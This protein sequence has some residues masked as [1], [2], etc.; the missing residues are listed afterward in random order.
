MLWSEDELAAFLCC[1]GCG[2]DVAER[3]LARKV[4][5]VDHFIQM[6]D[7]QLEK[8]FGFTSTL[9]RRVVRRALRRFLEV[10][11]LQ[12]KV[13]GRRLADAMED[14]V[15]RDFVIPLEELKIDSE[16]S[17]GGFGMVYKGI[18]R[19]KVA[20]GQ[21]QAGRDYMVA[22]KDMKGDRSSRLYEL[23]KECR[24]MSS[25]HHPNL[26]NFIGICARLRVPG[27]KQY[28]LSELMDCSLFDIIHRP[29]KTMWFGELTVLIVIKLAEGMSAG[30][31]YMHEKRL[32]HA[33]LKS[34][35]ILIDHTSSSELVPKICDFGHA[36]VRTHPASHHRCGTPHWAAPEALRS[37]AIG[38][39]SDVFSWGV[40][41]WEMLSQALPHMHLTFAQVVGTV[42][43][44]GFLPEMDM[45]PPIPPGLNDLMMWSL[46]FAPHRRPHAK[47][48]RPQLKRI[49]KRA[50][51]KAL[52][53][54]TGFIEGVA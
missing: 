31:A 36:A 18:L 32:V 26:C 22:V 2:Q 51:T 15:L 9:Q 13:Q 10:D 35:N 1:L 21:L 4:R 48:L 30:I 54:L 20:R 50:R 39:K 45:L 40:M 37:E 6:S 23:L 19:P 47:E 34:S 52:G 8:D 33:D 44:S 28:I 41:L 7:A 12:N 27:S 5:G 25:L 3:V 29:Q 46:Q 17:Q 49:R 42:G 14:A 16:I 38:P 53:M 43:W 24:V 11:R